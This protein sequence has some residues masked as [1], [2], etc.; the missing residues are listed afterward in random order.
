MR[1]TFEPQLQFG[2][3]PIEEVKIPLRSRHEV[4]AILRS[5]QKIYCTQSINEKIFT[6]LSDKI[7]GD[8]KQ[9][10]CPGMDLWHILVL[11]VLRLATNA[12]YDQLEHY[13]NYDR[14]VRQIMGVD[15]NFDGYQVK[16]SRNAIHDNI[17][18]L[19][20]EILKQIN[21]IIISFGHNIIKKKR[22]RKIKS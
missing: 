15:N 6:I 12:N 5:L 8:K 3:I 14:L 20:S 1:K 2:S 10:G 7:I 11:G 19:D 22:E 17:S 18:Q 4:P 21:D 16:F 13:A 9:T